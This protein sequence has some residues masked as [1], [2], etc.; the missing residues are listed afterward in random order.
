M[1]LLNSLLNRST[2]SLTVGT[3]QGTR[4]DSLL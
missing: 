1:I 2:P 4:L 3:P